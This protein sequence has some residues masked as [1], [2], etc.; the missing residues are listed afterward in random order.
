MIKIK[1]KIKIKIVFQCGGGQFRDRG[2]PGAM[3]S[4]PAGRISLG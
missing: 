1:I 2:E 4:S 3:G